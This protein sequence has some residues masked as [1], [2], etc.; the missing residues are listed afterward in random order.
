MESDIYKAPSSD[1]SK[2]EEYEN[3]EFAGFWV[4]FVATIIDTILIMLLTFPLATVVYGK[5]YWDSEL[6][7]QGGWDIVISYVLPALVVIIFWIYKSATP[8]KMIFGIQVISLGP[9]RALSK[10]QAIGRYA[11]YYLSALCFLLGYVWVAFDK[12]KQGWH[13]K[14]ANTAV[15]IKK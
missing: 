11:A 6:F 7:I 4:R 9:Q 13:D 12:R 10:K 5:E 2:V 15:V 1:L 14:L 3:L 8:G